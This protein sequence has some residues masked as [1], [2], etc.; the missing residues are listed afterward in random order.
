MNWAIRGTGVYAT[1]FE[2]RRLE[3]IS[4]S[5]FGVQIPIT[6]RNPGTTV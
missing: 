2:L 4:P 6:N 1:N 5:P 3:E